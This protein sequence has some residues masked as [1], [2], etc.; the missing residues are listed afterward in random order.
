MTMTVFACGAKDSGLAKFGLT[1]GGSG[2][3]GWSRAIELEAMAAMRLVL[4]EAHRFFDNMQQGRQN[5]SENRHFATN[6]RA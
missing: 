6:A 5:N 1:P 3:A 4:T 2:I